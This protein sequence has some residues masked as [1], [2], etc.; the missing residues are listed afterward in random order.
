MGFAWQ[1]DRQSYKFI[2]GIQGVK[3][4]PQEA[5]DGSQRVEHLFSMCIILDLNPHK[6]GMVLYVY[7]LR[8][9]KT[10]MRWVCLYFQYMESSRD[11][12]S[13][14]QDHFFSH[15]E[16]Q[17]SLSNPR[18]C[19]PHAQQGGRVFFTIRTYNHLSF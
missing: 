1:F 6:P 11:R 10:D 14:I 5:G 13:K 7:S 8:E 19:P 9:V 17:V 15:S 2:V 12:G 18:A 16:N 3:M 4:N